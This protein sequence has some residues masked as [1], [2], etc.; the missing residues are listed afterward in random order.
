MK[1]AVKQMADE[2]GTVEVHN[3]EVIEPEIDLDINIRSEDLSIFESDSG[4][5]FL[6]TEQMPEDTYAEVV[7][8]S[9]GP[10]AELVVGVDAE[11]TECTPAERKEQPEVDTSVESTII[12]D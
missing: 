2:Q 7:P 1:Q 3:S 8:T 6:Q 5:M 12:V 10:I 9:E 4:Q 11:L